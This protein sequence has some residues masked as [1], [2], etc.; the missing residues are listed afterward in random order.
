MN[1]QDST[2]IDLKDS[3]NLYSKTIQ[4]SL[5]DLFNIEVKKDSTVESVQQLEEEENLY[6]SILF[7]GKIYGEFI[8]GLNRRTSMRLLGISPSARGDELEYQD[9][10]G[11][12]L[13]SFKEII[14]IGAGAA[15]HNLKKIDPDLTITSPKAIEGRLSLSSYKI[16][17]VKLLSDY[18][19]LS[20]YIYVD[21]MKLDVNEAI[22][23]NQRLNRAKSEFLAN[24]SHELRTPLN[25]M[26]GM[27]DLLKDSELTVTQ[28]RQFDVIYKSGEFL[29]SVI[30]DIL[31][32]SRIESGRIEIIH[33]KF[34][35]KNSC[36][37]VAESLAQVIYEKKLQYYV[38]IDPN[39]AD[40][41]LG[42][43]T[44]VKQILVNLIGNAVKFTPSGFIRLEVLTTESD[45]VRIKV[46]DSGVGIPSSKVD[47]IFDSF[48]QADLSD[49]RKYGGAGLGLTITKS[50]VNAMKGHIKV[51]STEAVGTTFTIE[52]PLD[53]IQK[54]K[55][56]ESLV[57]QVTSKRPSVYVLTKDASLFSILGDYLRNHGWEA[58]SPLGPF[59][60]LEFTYGE[61][62]EE[63][64]A[65]MGRD[66]VEEIVRRSGPI[67]IDYRS[68]RGLGK[69]SQSQWVQAFSGVPKKI[70]FVVE[71]CF[72]R[73]FHEQ[74]EV[75]LNSKAES[76]V[77]PCLDSDLDCFLKRSLESH[78]ANLDLKDQK[79][80]Q[81]PEGLLKKKAHLVALSPTQNKGRVLVVEDNPMNQ[82]VIGE[83]LKALGY[84]VEKAA[85]GA[86]AVLA[87]Q[88]SLQYE[89][90]LMDCQM[91]VMDGFQATKEIRRIEKGT[92][93][94]I[95]ALT[96]NAFR[97]TKESCFDAGMDDFATKP[98][99][100]EM[101]QNV[102]QRT[103][104]KLN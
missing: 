61:Y 68:W 14:N 90:V 22:E 67:L 84:S 54:E 28:K 104:M 34:N 5:R 16:E 41:Y 100:K 40:E 93:I 70:L 48:T 11:D 27:L 77:F 59:S 87:I 24:M 42:D 32:F 45:L 78:H 56:S 8:I 39:L 12:I 31:E 74:W 64:D 69:D 3:C 80:R 85:N 15:L 9:N 36:L 88:E 21:Y 92:H 51:E 103:L 53:R 79:E 25:G 18:G 50:I 29:L 94:P 4:K 96:A 102:I 13:D 47:I 30:S 89:F 33:K 60:R 58:E 76:L 66:S 81:E 97:E 63:G 95:I 6:F 83:M 26:I 20:C 44:R 1:L 17:R 91:P 7:T 49:S 72:L 75:R 19:N 52:F 86:Q 37:A 62:R 43:E 65:P 73:E 99:T 23:K 2:K 101:L 55:S 98:I 82:I 10:R 38:Y 57:P 46:S 71:S 35:L